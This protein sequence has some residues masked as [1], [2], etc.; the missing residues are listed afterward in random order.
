MT[1]VL[2]PNCGGRFNERYC[3]QCGQK[4]TQRLT[5]VQVTR[6]LTSQLLQLDFAFLRTAA[7]LTLGP[8]R[9]ARGYVKGQRRTYVNPIKYAFVTATV[10]VLVINF[11]KVEIVPPPGPFQL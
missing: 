3:G 11:F 9:V 8:G 5:F 7:H 10:Y 1:E 4:R 2:C 6:D